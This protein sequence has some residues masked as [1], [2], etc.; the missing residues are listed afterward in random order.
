[1]AV[2]EICGK[3]P[4]FGH[5]VSHS[6]RRT[7]RK[8]KPNLQRTTIMRDGRPVKVTICTKCLKTLNKDV[9]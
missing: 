9:V 3:K 6:M 7:K 1:M 4:Q 2:C 5:N 8:F